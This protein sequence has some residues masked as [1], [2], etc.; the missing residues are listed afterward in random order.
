M[1]SLQL[2]KP[3]LIVVVGLP[4]A[5]KSFFGKNFSKIFDAPFLDYQFF[6]NHAKNESASDQLIDE[7]LG[8]LLLS[9]QTLIIEGPG[10]TLR[11]RGELKKLARKK[12][13][14][15]LFVWVQ[16]ESAIAQKRSIAK[17]TK[18]YFDEYHKKFQPLTRFEPYVVIS[19]KHTNQTQAK[20][21]LK[22]IAESKDRG[23]I[24]PPPRDIQRKAI[25]NSRRVG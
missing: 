6:R 19:G 12:G 2:K 9:R 8:M 13:Y 7:V 20:T 16:T 25:I 14:E 24:T 17:G 15:L 1:G 23:S 21:V 11:G 4:G 10:Y 3:F 5:G 22:K 18:K